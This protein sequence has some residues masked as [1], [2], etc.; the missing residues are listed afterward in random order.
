MCAS[1]LIAT[2]QFAFSFFFSFFLSSYPRPLF[3]FIYFSSCSA[4]VFVCRRALS[5]YFPNSF[6]RESFIQQEKECTHKLFSV[7]MPELLWYTPHYTVERLGIQFVEYCGVHKKSDWL[8]NT[9]FKTHLDD[10]FYVRNGVY[11]TLY[12]VVY[13]VYNNNNNIKCDYNGHIHMYMCVLYINNKECH[14]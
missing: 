7:T 14:F 13:V 12:Y 9:N 4:F 5:L 6:N 10:T 8:S 11:G 2:H 3:L 1:I